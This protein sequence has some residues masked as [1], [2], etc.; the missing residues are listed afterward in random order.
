MRNRLS[1][2][3]PFNQQTGWA[4]RGSLCGAGQARP[5]S[6]RID[7][8]LCVS[9]LHDAH[10]FLQRP[11]SCCRR[12]RSSS[13]KQRWLCEAHVLQQGLHTLVQPHQASNFRLSGTDGDGASSPGTTTLRLQHGRFHLNGGPVVRA[14]RLGRRLL[15]TQVLHHI[16]RVLIQPPEPLVLG[17]ADLAWR[18][19]GRGDIFEARRIIPAAT[20]G[21]VCLQIQRHLS[22]GAEGA[23]R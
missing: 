14:S 17:F 4:R 1:Q 13:G 7:P 21:F 8:I 19:A 5:L 16:V 20:G 12:V 6:V 18:A 9:L 3:A 10:V 2:G 23:R 15:D 22:D 11:A